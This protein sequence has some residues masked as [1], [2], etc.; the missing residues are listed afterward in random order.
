MNWSDFCIL[1]ISGEKL[2]CSFR[3]TSSTP[4]IPLLAFHPKL[5]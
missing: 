3:R 2:R 1:H 4:F 5:H